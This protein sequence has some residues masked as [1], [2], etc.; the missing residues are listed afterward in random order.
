[1]NGQIYRKT[2][3]QIDKWIKRLKD[4]QINKQVDKWIDR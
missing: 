3:G 4:R 1:M 2:M